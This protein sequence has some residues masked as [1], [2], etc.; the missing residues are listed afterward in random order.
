MTHGTALH[1]IHGRQRGFSDGRRHKASRPRSRAH[2]GKARGSK[3]AIE[4]QSFKEPAATH[5]CKARGIHERVRSLIMTL[6]PSPC[7]FLDIRWYVNYIHGLRVL[8][9]P[10]GT[11]CH[12]VAVTSPEKRPDLT[13]ARGCSRAAA[14]LAPPIGLSPLRGDGRDTTQAPPRSSCLR[15]SCAVDDG[16]EVVDRFGIR[17]PDELIEQ[18]LT[19]SWTELGDKTLADQS[20]S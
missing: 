20:G 14:G 12:R 1:I 17:K 11:A 2:L 6:K 10:Q 19:S 18:V 9:E 3:I 15:I 7:F 13:E 8:D 4:S 5:H 16:V